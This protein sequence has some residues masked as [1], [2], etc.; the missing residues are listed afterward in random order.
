VLQ[1]YAV[2]G[3]GDGASKAPGSTLIGFRTSGGAARD[4]ALAA[5]HPVILEF[6]TDLNVPP[7]PPH[8]T[9]KGALHFIT[10]IPSEPELSSAFANS[11]RQLIATFLPG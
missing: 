9:A 3:A 7:L 1:Q 8:I 4:E 5:D 11:A 6:F 2:L 10:M